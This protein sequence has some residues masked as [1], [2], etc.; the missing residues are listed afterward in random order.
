MWSVTEGTGGSEG[1]PE[2]LL[3]RLIQREASAAREGFSN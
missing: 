3:G 1:V 2:E